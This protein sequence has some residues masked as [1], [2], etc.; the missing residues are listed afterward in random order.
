MR[1]P[2]VP[3]TGNNSY[4]VTI[5]FF[6]EGRCQEASAGSAVRPLLDGRVCMR[7]ERYRNVIIGSGEGGKYL[8]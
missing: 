6:G 5:R 2:T 4:V 7:I 3:F 8:A 1:M